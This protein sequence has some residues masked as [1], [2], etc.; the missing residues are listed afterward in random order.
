MP[1]ADPP[2]RPALRARYDERRAALIDAAAKL[3][4]ERGYEATSIGDLSEATG[5]AAG[6][7]YHYTAS[8]ED[9]L[10]AICDELLD[11]LLER[12]RAIAATD[13]SPEEHLRE[14]LRAWLLHIER[15]IPHML[16]FGQERHTIEREPR[17]RAV[18]RKRKQFEQI[19]DAV[20]VAG[21]ADGSMSF[22]DRGLALLA[23]LGMV[24]YA[25][26]WLRPNGRRSAEE[27]AD[28]WCDL[29]LAP[30]TRT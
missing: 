24:N 12:A 4:A 11:P 7:I 26:Q 21:E 10:I 2:T 9:L 8:K 25:P 5:L 28:V 19:L 14:L 3:F 1:S 29:F 15:H 16:V 20:L 6:G 22:E 17:W 23:L 13:A 27:I 18:R 30:S